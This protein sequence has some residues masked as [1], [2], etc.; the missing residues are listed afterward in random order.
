MLLFSQF[1]DLDRAHET[2]WGESD[3]FLAD[4]SEIV[5]EFDIGRC[6]ARDLRMEL[7]AGNPV[8]PVIDDLD[9]KTSCA[10]PELIGHIDPERGCPDYSLVDAVEPDP[11]EA[12]IQD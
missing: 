2:R 3:G 10:F 9:V 11:R 1:H 5:Y 12:H 7:V 8:I 4:S 6:G